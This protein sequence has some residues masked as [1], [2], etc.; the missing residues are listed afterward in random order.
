MI[1][2]FIKIWFS[3]AVFRLL[4]VTLTF[5]NCIKV[6]KCYVTTKI[7]P[8]APLLKKIARKHTIGIY[9]S[10]VLMLRRIRFLCIF[11]MND[12]VV[13]LI[14]STYTFGTIYAGIYQV[15]TVQESVP[16]PYFIGTCYIKS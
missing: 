8:A 3:L 14:L 16:T 12:R 1:V 11:K 2:P 4:T 9:I 15:R 6:E 10:T 7:T 13:L 5:F